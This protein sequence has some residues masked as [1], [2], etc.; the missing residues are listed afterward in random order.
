MYEDYA[1]L[2]LL[3]NPIMEAIIQIN[4]LI[5][6]VFTLFCIV[7]LIYMIIEIWNNRRR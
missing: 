6:N 2:K 1:W 7:V 5:T 3:G 4:S